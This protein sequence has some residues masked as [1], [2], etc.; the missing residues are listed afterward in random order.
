MLLTTVAT[1]PQIKQVKKN[2]TK[3]GNLV[4]IYRRQDNAARRNVM[5]KQKPSNCNILTA[6]KFTWILTCSGCLQ[7]MKSSLLYPHSA[8]CLLL[9]RQDVLYRRLQL[10]IYWESCLTNNSKSALQR[11][12]TQAGTRFNQRDAS[13]T[14]FAKKAKPKLL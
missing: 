7:V 11:Q 4:S 10:F 14:V 5:H 12:S 13:P 3:Y 9:L 1:I 8:K 2:N 6:S